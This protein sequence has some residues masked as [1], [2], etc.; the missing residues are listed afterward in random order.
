[1][2]KL[3]TTRKTKEVSELEKETSSVRY[4]T[5]TYNPE[6]KTVAVDF[7]GTLVFNKYPYIENPNMTLI[8]YIKEHR[9][10][11][12]WILYTCREGVQLKYAVDYMKNEHGIEFDFVNENLPHLIE[13]FGDSRKIW[14]DYYVDDKG[15]NALFF[16]YEVEKYLHKGGK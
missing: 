14:A 8:N 3:R 11:Y 9:H 13:S 7:D 12:T 4:G 1:M 5:R 15:I 6:N 10:D 2:R 16:G